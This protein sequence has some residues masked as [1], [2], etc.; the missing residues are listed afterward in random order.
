MILVQMTFVPHNK[1]LYYN[2]L[3]DNI[4]HTEM[5]RWMDG[6]KDGRK[7]G[8]RHGWTQRFSGFK[9]LTKFTG[10]FLASGYM[11]QHMLHDS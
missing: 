7:E 5:D 2:T 9:L 8:W 1:A 3:M 10:G 4:Q 6:K 11:T